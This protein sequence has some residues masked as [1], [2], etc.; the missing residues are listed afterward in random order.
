LTDVD[1]KTTV[2]GIRA[3]N[4]ALRQLEYAARRRVVSAAVRAGAVVVQKEARQHA[5]VGV[6][7]QLRKQLRTSVKMDR[8]TGTVAATISGRATKANKA[9]GQVAWYTRLVIEGTKPHAIRPAVAGGLAFGDGV[10]SGVMH[11]G[12]KPNPFMEQAADS[13]SAAAIAAFDARF[14]EKMEEE[15]A[16]TAAAVRTMG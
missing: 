13:A 6:T 14:A 9:K 15:I 16:K 11:P 8:S 12:A 1:I 10:Y 5:P 3:S 7:G 2:T 4:E